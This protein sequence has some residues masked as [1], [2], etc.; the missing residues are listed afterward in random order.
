VSLFVD[1]SAL[2]A[3]ALRDVLG[4]DADFEREGFRL[5]P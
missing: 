5:I 4:L 3:E 2:Y 1:T